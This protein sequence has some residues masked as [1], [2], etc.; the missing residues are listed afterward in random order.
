MNISDLVGLLVLLV[1]FRLI[2][3]VLTR[4]GQATSSPELAR[5]ANEEGRA[6]EE[7]TPSVPEPPLTSARRTLS[8]RSI[9]RDGTP[10]SEADGGKSL[11]G[12][13]GGVSDERSQPVS[14]RTDVPDQGGRRGPFDDLVRESPLVAGIVMRE[15]LGSPRAKKPYR[16]LEH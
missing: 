2:R 8:S 5:S 11:D 4:L 3:G 1:V 14:A 12:D 16:P 13:A 6:T 10:V 7:A 15:V 9:R